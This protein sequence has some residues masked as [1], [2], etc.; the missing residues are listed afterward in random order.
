MAQISNYIHCKDNILQLEMP[1]K[2][3][4]NPYYDYPYMII[5]DFFSQNNIEQLNKLLRIDDDIEDAK[6]RKVT[7]INSVDQKLDK[8]IRKTKI[9]R[10]PDEFNNLYAKQFKFF[11]TKIED[12]FRLALTTSTNIQILEYTKGSF[13]KAHSDDSNMLLKDDKLV[14]F[15]TVANQRK[16]TTVLFLSDD[17]EGGELVFNYLLTQDNKS[18][19]IR[20]KS[21]QMIVFLSNPIFTHEVKEVTS[22]NRFTLVQWH[23]AVL[24]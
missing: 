13:Y 2:L 22:G 7:K 19:K 8:K 10:I 17:Y 4:P 24:N 1:T 16:I 12:F 18:V 21:G 9:H 15:K 23:D 6:V 20:G 14:G 3:F 5:D 11:Q